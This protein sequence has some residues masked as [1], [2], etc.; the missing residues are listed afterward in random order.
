MGI[1]R[2]RSRDLFTLPDQAPSTSSAASSDFRLVVTGMVEAGVVGI[3]QRVTL[4]RAGQ[5]IRTLEIGGI[6][7]ARRIVKRAEA[8]EAV[9]L[10]FRGTVKDDIVNGDV[11]RT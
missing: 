7:R 6:E 9:G 3:G 11:I 5:A 8:G 10:L 1:F 2:R 4:E